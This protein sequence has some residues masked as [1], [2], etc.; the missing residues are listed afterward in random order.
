M[1]TAQKKTTTTLNSEVLDVSIPRTLAMERLRGKYAWRAFGQPS[2]D[3]SFQ[4][5][6]DCKYAALHSPAA[7]EIVSDFGRR[8]YADIAGGGNFGGV[9]K[10]IPDG[11]KAAIDKLTS[12]KEKIL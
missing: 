10:D 11:V 3:A 8:F 6:V 9:V 7:L 2:F 4:Y 1:T 5:A 12:D